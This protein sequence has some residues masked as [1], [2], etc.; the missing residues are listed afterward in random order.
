M[1]STSSKSSKSGKS[2]T[3]PED[4]KDGKNKISNRILFQLPPPDQIPK[5]SIDIVKTSVKLLKKT[6]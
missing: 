3:S 5:V 6:G 4:N 1:I 2:T